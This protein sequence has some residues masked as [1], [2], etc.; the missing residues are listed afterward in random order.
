M[1]SG[2]RRSSELAQFAGCCIPVMAQNQWRKGL[3]DVRLVGTVQKRATCGVS[4]RN[5]VR[6]DSRW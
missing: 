1:R 6:M 5:C 2:R 4:W 3:L